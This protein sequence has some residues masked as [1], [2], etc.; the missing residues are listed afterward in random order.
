MECCQMNNKKLSITKQIVSMTEISKMLQLSRAR[1]YQLLQSGFFPKPKYDSRSK[2]PYYD[3]ALQ[4]KCLECRQ[5]G[6]GIDNSYMLFYS[7]RKKET[8]SHLAKKKIDPVIKELTETLETMGL[9]ITVKQVQRAISELYHEGVGDQD[10]GVVVREL[11]RHFK[12]LM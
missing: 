8:V 7:S 6:I 3:L 5:S 9:D 4:Q 12:Q 11:F 10:Q 2:R 1:F